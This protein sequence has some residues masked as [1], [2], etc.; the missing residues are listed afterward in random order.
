VLGCS[1]AFS[2]G[3]RLFPTFYVESEAFRFL[4]DCGPTAVLAMK[5]A[6]IDP[7]SLDAVL[8][9]HF[10]GDHFAGLPFLEIELDI[11]RNR[12]RPLIVGGPQ[13]VADR[14][15][16]ISRDA[17]PSDDGDQRVEYQ[18]IEWEDEQAVS[19]GPLRV[20]A[21]PVVHAPESLPYGLRVEV[22]GR[23]LAYSGDSEWCDALVR[24]A[25]RA[26]LFICE[27]LT[28]SRDV[29]NHLSYETLMAHRSELTCRRLLI[30]HMSDDM[31]EHL[32]VDGAE[33][34]FDGLVI[35]V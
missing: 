8:L 10:H 5:R 13:G 21:V 16:A 34:A 33:A 3:G 1:D 25:A 15:R 27:S 2:S 7:D 24:I 12:K 17:Y 18:F 14:V 20:E 6:G 11:M 29:R 26:D 19:V 30:T 22:D 9:S 28:F 23:M 35:D 4:L 31:L 32:P